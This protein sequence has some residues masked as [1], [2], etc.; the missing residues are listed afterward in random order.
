ME[1]IQVFFPAPSGKFVDGNELFIPIEADFVKRK[2]LNLQYAPG[3]D[4]RQ[5]D[6]YLPNG[7]NA[8]YPVIIDI[9]GGG[10]YFGNK[11]SFKMEPA[12]NLL[13]RGFAVVSPNYTLSKDAKYPLPIHEIKAA[14]RYI[15]AKGEQYGLDTKRIA[16]M[17]ESAGAHIAA[18]CATSASFPVLEDLSMGNAEYDSTVQA[19]IAVYC[20]SDLSM[21]NAQFKAMNVTPEFEDNDGPDSFL[22]VLFGRK[23]LWEIKEEVD[24]VNPIRYVSEKCPPFLFLHG[25]RDRQVPILQSLNLAAEIIQKA[26]PDKAEHHIIEGAEHNIFDF[27]TDEIYDIEEKF[28]RKHL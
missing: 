23:S 28:L 6:I 19:V 8:P 16:L 1:R 5:L 2:Y 11:S 7:G 24:K 21:F 15:K 14:I 10:W 18:L 27:E 20:P 26:G 12:L 3:N 9:F 22:G 4:R 17:G 13:K 25:S